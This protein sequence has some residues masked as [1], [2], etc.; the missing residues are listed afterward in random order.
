[1]G[2]YRSGKRFEPG[3]GCRSPG[4]AR[5]EYC[6]SDI[7]QIY[8][9][10]VV[11]VDSL[12]RPEHLGLALETNLIRAAAPGAIYQGIK[13]AANDAA[14]DIRA[15]DPHVL[16]SVSVQA[17]VAW[18]KLNG[19]GPGSG[20]YVGVSPDLTDFPF[21]QELGISSYPYLSFSVPGDMPLD[22]YSKLVEGHSLPVFVSE[23]GW[24]SMP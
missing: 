1:M 7:Q 16:L 20:G 8:R 3:V 9:R 15:F 11:V 22:Y 14:A 18:G 23:G 21:V 6:E 17:E 24:T 10:W 13:K 5:K 19:S 2:I 4:G 12:V